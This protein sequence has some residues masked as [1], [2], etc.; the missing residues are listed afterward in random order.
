MRKISYWSSVEKPK[1]PQ[2]KFPVGLIG[3]NTEGVGTDAFSSTPNA[4]RSG[5][6]A[7][8]MSKEP[9]MGLGVDPDKYEHQIPKEPTGQSMVDEE[10]LELFV[11]LGDEMDNAEEHALADFADYMLRKIAESKKIDFI[12]KFNELMIKVNNSDLSDRNET[13]KKLT[14]IF[15]RTLLLESM[16]QNDMDKA[17]ESA[18]KKTLHRA[19][20]YLAEE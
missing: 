10:I 17:K 18:Y 20:Q 8:E 6:A 4:N 15:S 11:N 1:K 2:K 9:E 12:R 5:I 3:R 19:D 7:V 13:I 14:K 16:N